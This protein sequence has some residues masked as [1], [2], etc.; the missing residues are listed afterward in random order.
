MQ[1][2]GTLKNWDLVISDLKQT[3]F[4][5]LL[6]NGVWQNGLLHNCPIKGNT[7]RMWL[8]KTHDVTSPWLNLNVNFLLL[9]PCYSLSVPIWRTS[10]PCVYLFWRRSPIKHWLYTCTVLYSA[11]GTQI[12][13]HTQ[14]WSILVC[15]HFQASMLHKVE[16][17][18][19][20]F[21]ET[22]NIITRTF[23]VRDYNVCHTL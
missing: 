20:H 16:P 2:S 8:W 6:E 17:F 14:V 4:I 13:V 23:N 5:E 22:S 12:S 7:R 9:L 19:L 21:L 18:V 3:A 10:I 15:C 11:F 1:N